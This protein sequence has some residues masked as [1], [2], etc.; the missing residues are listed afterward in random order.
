MKLTN[1]LSDVAS[2]IFSSIPFGKSAD[3][4]ETNGFLRMQAKNNRFKPHVRAAWNINFESYLRE[5]NHMGKHFRNINYLNH[6]Q[7]HRSCQ[8]APQCGHRGT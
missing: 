6:L 7:I 2:D 4:F 3:G 5:A 8:D 1:G